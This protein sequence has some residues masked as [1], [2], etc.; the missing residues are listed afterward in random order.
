MLKIK[1]E[2]EL[3]A[4]AFDSRLKD[5]I[6]NGHIPDLRKMQNCDWFY[7]NVWRRPYLVNM[8][9]GKILQFAL[10]NLRARSKVLEVG[11]GPGY[12]SLELARN[13]FDV[14]GLDISEYCIQIANQYKQEN[15]FLDGF[16]SLEY[17][18]NDF[19]TFDFSENSFDAICFFQTLHHFNQP[20]V[21]IHKVKRLLKPG[22]IIIVNEPARDMIT[23]KDAA[24]YALIRVLL[25]VSNHWYEK[26]PIPVAEEEVDS[27]VKECLTEYIDAKDYDEGVQS[28]HDNSSY[29][30]EILKNLERNF[31]RCCFEWDYSFVPRIVG[32]L[33]FESEEKMKET[34]EFLKTFDLYAIK[35]GLIQP[36]GFFYA[37]TVK[38]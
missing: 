12:I 8:V 23:Q 11:C 3:E 22:G 32:G 9:Y 13:G 29:S 21:I 27:F 7:N 18:K 20:A 2:M 17:L 26:R 31:S 14:L 28:V 34:A 24:L 25:S 33:R 37:G 30:N 1:N 6:N 35:L 4:E 5:R 16:G 19:T 38:K 10:T 15:T 36:G